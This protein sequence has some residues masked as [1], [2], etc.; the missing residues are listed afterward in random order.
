MA[1]I[2]VTQS[3]HDG[4]PRSDWPE[5]LLVSPA[6]DQWTARTCPA[7]LYNSYDPEAPFMVLITSYSWFLVS[8][9]PVQGCRCSQLLVTDVFL[10]LLGPSQLPG[11]HLA[12]CSHMSMCIYVDCLSPSMLWVMAWSSVDRV[13]CGV[14][15]VFRKHLMTEWMDAWVNGCS[16][17][18][19]CSCSDGSDR[20]C[21]P[22]APCACRYKFLHLW[23]CLLK[24]TLCTPGP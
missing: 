22:V 9:S 20:L 1:A 19:W 14:E 3:W 6:E 23:I 12:L 11:Q 24:F 18:V 21:G 10:S 5:Q 7:T 15:W 13:M 17:K 4:I 8:V 2:K 16:P